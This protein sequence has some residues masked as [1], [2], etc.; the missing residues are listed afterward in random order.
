[1]AKGSW[2][3]FGMEIDTE[4]RSDLKWD[5]IKQSISPL[6]GRLV[7]DVGC[8]NGYYSY[9]IAGEEAKLALGAD[10]FLLYVL[11]S[12]LAPTLPPPELPSVCR[13][14]GN[15]NVTLPSAFLR[16][17]A[18]NGSSLPSEISPR[19]FARVKGPSAGKRGNSSWK[20]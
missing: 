13:S 10:P 2:N 9:R 16:Y 6:K 4:W 17:G 11:Q 20:H 12:L 5:R 19:P 1:M 14:P 7:L 18:V 15:R 3:Y 8:G